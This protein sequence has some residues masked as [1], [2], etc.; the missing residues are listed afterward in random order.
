MKMFINYN[1]KDFYKLWNILSKDSYLV[2][3]YQKNQLEYISQRPKDEGMKVENISFIMLLNDIPVAGFI[4]AAVEELGVVKVLA[5]EMPAVFIE[6]RAALTRKA[7]KAFL[8]EFDNRVDGCEHLYL[9]DHL[10]QGAAST[11]TNHLLKNGAVPTPRLSQIID[12]NEEKALLWRNIRKR[13]S[14]L[15]NN[16]LR[17]LSPEIIDSKNI[18][19][20]LMQKFRELHIREAGRETRSAESWKRQYEMVKADE[21]FVIVGRV[22]NIVVSAGLF[23]YNQTNCYY[24]VSASRRDLF[25]KPLFHAIMWTAILN[26]K[27][28]GLR[29]FEVGEQLY[30]NHPVG[31]KPTK[32]ELGISDFKAGFGGETRVFL[33]ARIHIINAQV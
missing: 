19:W 33:D 24:W 26:A 18:T 22:D 16:G 29:W 1:H 12:L 30:P 10:H 14:S 23:A 25:D 17:D 6:N 3:F 11:L 31:N 9:T 28:L 21:A 20:E 15:I 32:K 4:G 2:P 8:K 27:E 5:Y 13:Y 7:G